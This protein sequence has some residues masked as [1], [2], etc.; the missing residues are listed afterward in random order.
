MIRKTI[1]GGSDLEQVDEQDTPEPQGSGSAL[2]ERIL[3]YLKEQIGE[4]GKHAIISSKS[5]AQRFAVTP[6][7]VAKHLHVLVQEGH[8]RTKP[9]GP[10]GTIITLESAPKKRG[11]PATTSTLVGQKASGRDTRR[12]AN[13]SF[14]V[15]CGSKV[16][17][18]WRYCNRCGHALPQ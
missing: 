2:R 17:K 9:A 8:I 18:Q 4:V 6:V 13:G 14:C 10:K 5:I 3:A 12:T 11:R 7:T 15:W 16:E 1:G